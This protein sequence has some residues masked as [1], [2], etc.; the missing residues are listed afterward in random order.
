[1]LYPEL[2]I[3]PEILD[4]IFDYLHPERWH[5][6]GR[7]AAK[8]K[9]DLH[10]C[11]LVSRSWY[12]LSQEH[13]FR[14]IVF[15]FRTTL[16]DHEDIPDDVE[17]CGRWVRRM[18]SPM[19]PHK[20]LFM[21]VDFLR[22]CP[23]LARSI[24]RLALYAHSP[25]VTR[26]RAV[27]LGVGKWV[28]QWRSQDRIEA[29]T[30]SA[31]LKC[32]SRLQELH[33]SNVVLS[34]PAH[35]YP[36]PYRPALQCLHVTLGDWH[37]SSVDLPALLRHFDKV[38][39]LQ[40]NGIDFPAGTQ[41]ERIPAYAMGT[42]AAVPRL[43]WHGRCSP[44]S[45]FTA[46]L[47]RSLHLQTIRK[48]ALLVV[49]PSPELQELVELTGPQLEELRLRIMP[50]PFEDPREHHIC[51][52]SSPSRLT[53][54]VRSQRANPHDHRLQQLARYHHRV[55]FTLRGS[56][57]FARSHAE[58]VTLLRSR[59]NISLAVRTPYEHHLRNRLPRPPVQ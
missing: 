30:L 5:C 22:Q 23:T 45:G 32:T 52:F 37:P 51:L 15:S 44:P 34:R 36:P 10:A 56:R 53:P 14:N 2:A 9:S 25:I 46:A 7:E 59:E 13:L 33:L 12:P 20:T 38:E 39:G 49:E 1:M 54:Y 48:L 40:L 57:A 4:N 16:D 8:A 41:N 29:S 58:G 21:F 28:S 26:T 55:E 27:G 24:R 19:A 42:Q 50:E 3:P 43:T 31:L 17:M 35:N 47:S 11:T 6:P 18:G